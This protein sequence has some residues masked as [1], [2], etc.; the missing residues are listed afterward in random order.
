M[1]YNNNEKAEIA[2]FLRLLASQ[3]FF[4]WRNET[5]T[6]QYEYRTKQGYQRRALLNAGAI[7]S[8]DI[9]GVAPDGRFV[10][11]EV[12]T[13]KT[14]KAQGLSAVQRDFKARVEKNDGIFWLVDGGIDHL[15]GLLDS[16]FVSKVCY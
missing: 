7:G 16:F 4:C 10:G 8:P 12:K 15:R 6:V 13:S 14:M 9:I 1:K 2:I 3:G 5:R 11:I